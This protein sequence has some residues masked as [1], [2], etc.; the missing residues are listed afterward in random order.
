MTKWWVMAAAA[1]SLC[2]PG[3][4]AHS[5]KRTDPCG[6]HHEWGLR[7]CHPNKKKQ[8]C[9]APVDARGPTSERT[10]QKPAPATAPQA[11]PEA[12]PEAL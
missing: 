12:R 5:S 11:V 2:A 6:C 9:E 3:A 1:A 10:R 8:T 4:W 7:H